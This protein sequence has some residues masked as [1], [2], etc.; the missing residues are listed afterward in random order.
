VQHF[1][2][3]ADDIMLTKVLCVQFTS[4]QNNVILSRMFGLTDIIKALF[5][6][7]ACK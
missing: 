1:L 3:A 2:L 7:F 6:Y 5:N 4:K